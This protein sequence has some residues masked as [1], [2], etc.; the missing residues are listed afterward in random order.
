MTAGDP[1]VA[2]SGAPVGP[3]NSGIVPPGLVMKTAL[4]CVSPIAST[5]GQFDAGYLGL[6]E[7]REACRDL[8]R[9]KSSRYRLR[10]NPARSILGVNDLRAVRPDGLHQAQHLLERLRTYPDIELRNT[11]FYNVPLRKLITPQLTVTDSRVEAHVRRISPTASEAEKIEFVS[12]RG[13]RGDL[14]DHQMLA[15]PLGGANQFTT[16]H[17][18]V[19]IYL[20]PRLV[21]IPV[22]DRD[23][24]G[25]SVQALAFPVAEGLPVIH[26]YKFRIEGGGER[27]VLANGV[28]R[29]VGA[30]RSGIDFLPIPVCDVEL[31]DLPEPFVELSLAWATNPTQNPPLA[32][33]FLDNSIAMHLGFYPGRKAIRLNWNVEQTLVLEKGGP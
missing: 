13:P 30:I 11:Q 33:D 9:E 10:R 7:T 24:D 1:I 25:G 20:P 15:V 18:D 16:E 5:V 4:Y 19:R 22:N 6:P 2:D 29:V 32:A 31:G 26:A 17:E 14:F 23:P 21:T 8:W 28:H 27:L 3:S 12:G